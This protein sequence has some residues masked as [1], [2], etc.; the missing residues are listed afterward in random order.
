MT[1]GKRIA[2]LRKQK[3]ISQSELAQ[4]LNVSPSTIG[5]WETDQRAIKDDNLSS[6]ADYFS[7]TTDYLLGRNQAPD[8]ADKDDLIELDKILDSNVDMAYGGETLT[9]EE[10]QRVKDILTGLFWEFRKEDKNKE[11]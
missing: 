4:A 6:L 3:G 1:I 9:D 2:E 10:R 8:W 11:K 5:M 7:V